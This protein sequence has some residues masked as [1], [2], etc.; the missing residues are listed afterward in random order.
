MSVGLISFNT[1]APS[2]AWDPLTD[3][4]LSGAILYDFD[5][6]SGVATSG[7]TVTSW[8]SRVGA[9]VATPPS[10]G[11]QYSSTARNGRPGVVFNNN[12]AERLNFTPTGMPTGSADG[13]TIV[14]GYNSGSGLVSIAAGYGNGT[15]DGDSRLVT[16][17]ATNMVQTSYRGVLLTT[18][19]GWASVDKIVIMSHNSPS[20]TEVRI[21]GRPEQ[22][23]QF[24][25]AWNTS[26][27]KGRIGASTDDYAPWTGVIQRVIFINRKLTTLEK[28]KFAGYLAHRY[29]LTGLL[30]SNH[31]YKTIAPT[32]S[33]TA[34]DEPD[35]GYGS[36]FADNFA[37]LSLRTGTVWSGNN[38][39]YN[40]PASKGTWSP[41]GHYYMTDPNSYSDYGWGKFLNPN[42]NWQATD[43]NFPALA[44][45]DITNSGVVLKGSEYYPLIRAALPL[46]GASRPSLLSSM[47]CTAQSMKIKS[48]YSR[49]FVFISGDS[50]DPNTYPAEF[51]ALWGL[52]DLYNGGIPI[53]ASAVGSVLT[54]TAV[55]TGP[56]NQLAIKPKMKIFG[57][58]SGIS[59][60]EIAS[61]GTGTGGT[62]TYNL[63]GRVPTNFTASISG[64]TLTVTVS[65]PGTYLFP[66][67]VVTGTGVAAN[68]T[69]TAK[70]TGNW[71]AGTYTVSVS[72]TVTSRTMSTNAPSA[73]N[74]I[75]FNHL[76]VD[77]YERFADEYSNLTTGQRTHMPIGYYDRGDAFNLGV[78]QVGVQH[79]IKLVHNDDYLYLYTDGVLTWKIANLYDSTDNLNH[80]V[81]NMSCGLS[82]HGHPGVFTG[83]MSG[84][85][86]TATV[87]DA[88][89]RIF[90]GSTITGNGI[91]AGTV[92]QSYGTNGTTGTGKTGTY[93][94]NT[95]GT[96]ASSPWFMA[97][98][99]VKES[100]M[101]VRRVEVF[102]PLSNTSAIVPPNPP[103]PITT[104]GGGFTGG[105][106]PN[107][108]ASGTNIAT[109]SGASTYT[110]MPYRSTFT[111]LTVVGSNLRTSGVLTPG[112]YDFYIRGVDA[113]GVPGIAPKKTLTIPP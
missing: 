50:T 107:T 90:A 57:N 64:T 38:T 112:T 24:T 6:M 58:G 21:D 48:P 83:S 51:P 13:T 12:A 70:L 29:G 96:A 106:I 74:T 82:W 98:G 20:L 68:T 45:L 67:L 53:T 26:A 78:G 76:E 85:T 8:T 18:T 99:V 2:T 87:V 108:T 25:T 71:E 103:V 66:G 65:D 94:V 101:T 102:A 16:V 15:T 27:A 17:S 43:P 9:G 75:S 109:L 35:S 42:A 54:V 49:E 113:S 7:S 104:W 62:G 79:T 56:P 91:P 77:D 93:A 4:A 22:S 105:S 89:A 61:Y 32:T 46:N 19:I 81:M 111:S 100:F 1:S 33:N 95:S 55:G 92:V 23:F 86:V 88:G 40:D 10:T 39:G 30:A 36:V 72:Q 60:L 14:V 37:C 69:I 63:V 34:T 59:Y 5:A 73:G 3:S 11:P 80:I 97:D 110:V 84:S 52:S 47:I 41:L 44:M 31:P 28:A